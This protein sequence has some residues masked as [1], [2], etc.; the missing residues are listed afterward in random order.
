MNKILVITEFLGITEL[1]DGALESQHKSHGKGINP[2]PK[3]AE[4]EE[5]LGISAL[6]RELGMQSTHCS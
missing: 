2:A 5:N 3:A 4:E 6:G 1:R